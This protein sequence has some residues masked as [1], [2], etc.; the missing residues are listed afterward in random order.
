[1][2]ASRHCAGS[3]KNWLSVQAAEKHINSK[4]EFASL[5]GL[6]DE[7]LNIS[8]R[9]RAI[10]FHC[11]NSTRTFRLNR[12]NTLAWWEYDFES[13]KLFYTPDATLAAIEREC[14][15]IEVSGLRLYSLHEGSDC[16]WGLGDPFLRGD[17]REI[18]VYEPRRRLSV[19][20]GLTKRI[21]SA[22]SAAI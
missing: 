3:L 12:D 21:A 7:V 4:L 1:M 17:G 6:R 5:E 11:V 19:F 13:G 8:A 22:G 9:Y 16:V 15:K 18:I 10:T 2:S 20:E 14:T